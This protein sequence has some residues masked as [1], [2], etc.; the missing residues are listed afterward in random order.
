MMKKIGTTGETVGGIVTKVSFDDEI[1]RGLAQIELQYKN[2]SVK[3]V[4]NLYFLIM[5]HVG[6]KGGLE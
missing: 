5:N 1:N 2:L 4:E 6:S 3:E